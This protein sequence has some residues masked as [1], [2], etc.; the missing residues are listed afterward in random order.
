MHSSLTRM[1]AAT[2]FA[3]PSLSSADSTLPTVVVTAERIAQT[4]EDS[5]ASITIIER[6]QIKQAQSLPELLR[7]VPGLSLSNS[8]GLGQSSSVFL[9]G[10]ESDHVLVLID[11]IKVGSPT[12]GNTAF[13]HIPITQIER[14]EIVRGPRSSLYGS[15]AIGGVIQ[16]FTRKGK[17]KVK[18]NFSLGGGSDNTYQATLGLS[19][20]GDQSWFS[21]NMSGVDTEGF[22][23][24]TGEPNVGGCWTHEPDKD[25]YQ[26]F[27]GQLRAGYRFSN[28]AE[29]DIHWLRTEAESNF[30]GTFQ[31]QS[32]TMQ[33]VLGAGFRILP[34]ENWTLSLKAGRSWDDSDNFKDS[35]FST[36]FET[37]RDTVWLQND[38][39]LGEDHLVLL[40][41]DYQNDEVGGT[42]LYPVTSRDKKGIFGQYLGYFA[43]HKLQFSLRNDEN[44]QF[45]NYTTGSLAWGYTFDNDIQF[46][47]NYGSAFKAPTFNELYFPNF[48][49]PNLKP[50]KSHS[51]EI[52]LSAKTTS[53]RLALNIYQT[54]I[55]ELIAYDASIFAPGN[56][57][58]AQIRGLE[59]ILETRFAQWDMKANLTLIDPINQSN[60]NLLPR[61]PK[62]SLNI[63]L[64]RQFQTFTVGTSL[65]AVGKTYDDA[66]NTR[67]LDAYMTMDIRAAYHFTKAWKV[68]VRLNNLFDEEYET[69]AFYQQTGRDFFITL[70]YQP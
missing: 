54:E 42:T 50:E 25:G 19:G 5:L 65:Y 24:C 47:A 7:R 10:T 60:D 46:S 16:I 15:E 43:Q 26:N 51:V 32:D 14:I 40:G 21:A 66:A 13:E 57:E 37:Q 30:D 45:G 48:G 18:A 11:G 23:S 36:R 64:E 63:N 69:A 61:R 56:L 39:A 49:N 27:S 31:N 29:I 67:E 2:L 9:R 28:Q 58:S 52:G 55:D 35:V 20:G 4:A 34:T 59:A 17:G 44:A 33:Q 41:L 3:L 53:G 68:Q 1:A 6:E 38:I 62:E 70:H 8:G 22:D 12:L